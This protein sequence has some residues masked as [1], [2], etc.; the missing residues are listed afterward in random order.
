MNKTLE[1]IK[2][3]RQFLLRQTE[4]LT[5]QQLNHIP[6]G[7]SNNII[8]NLGHLL[9]A[10]QNM[11]YVKAGVPITIDNRYF[12]LFLSGTKPEAPVD[13]HDIQTI[14]KLLITSLERLQSDLDKNLFENY[15]PS[16][17]IAKVYGFEVKNIHE[18]LEYLLYHEGLHSGYVLSLKRLL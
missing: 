3:F 10:E 16:V 7:S 1:K 6:A 17:A 8:W 15:S 9:A 13:S 11:C 12:T 14:R 4:D 5:E 2:G 18:A